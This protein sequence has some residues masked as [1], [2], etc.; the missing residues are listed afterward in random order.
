MLQ[1]RS[2][3]AAPPT[4]ALKIA[5]SL[6]VKA[7]HAARGVTRIEPGSLDQLHAADHRSQRPS[8][9]SSHSGLPAS[10]GAASAEIVVA[11]DEGLKGGSKGAEG[12]KKVHACAGSR[13]F[14]RGY[15]DGGCTPASGHFFN[16]PAGGHEPR[17]AAPWWARG[18]RA[19]KPCRWV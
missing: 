11:A 17:H 4:A 12:R 18:L 14:R 9:R 13:T 2:E 8:A 6:R 10:P 5:S 16:P 15:P 3:K 19:K 1:T 7:D